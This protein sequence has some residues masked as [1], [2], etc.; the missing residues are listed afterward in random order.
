MKLHTEDAFDTVT[1]RSHWA[2]FRRCSGLAKV[3]S[4][5]GGKGVCV[6]VY[7]CVSLCVCV[8]VYVCVWFSKVIDTL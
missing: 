4:W 5:S 2:L 1:E 3:F 6:C 7:V 8:C